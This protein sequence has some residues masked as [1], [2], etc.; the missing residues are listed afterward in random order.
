M[1]AR[2]IRIR[3]K[4]LDYRIRR[5]E[6]SFNLP[7]ITKELVRGTRWEAFAPIT[8]VLFQG[9]GNKGGIIALVTGVITGAA[10]IFS[11]KKNKVASKKQ[12][13]PKETSNNISDDQMFI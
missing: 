5:V 11:R 6:Q 10:A 4:I 13:Q 8:Q 9:K 12:Q 2:K 3:Q 7:N 1:L